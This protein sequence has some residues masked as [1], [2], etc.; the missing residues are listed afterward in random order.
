MAEKK[1]VGVTGFG[2][3]GSGVV[4]VLYQKEVSGLKLVKVADI[5]L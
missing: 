3:I 5:D 1:K 4:E 2:N